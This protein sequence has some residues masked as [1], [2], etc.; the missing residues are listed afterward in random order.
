MTEKEGVPSK[1]CRAGPTA[2]ERQKK[3]LAEALRKNLSRRKGLVQPEKLEGPDNS[4][5]E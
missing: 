4:S 1:V 2:A 3:R 5:R